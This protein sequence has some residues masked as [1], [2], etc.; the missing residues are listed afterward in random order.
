MIAKDPVAS[1]VLDREMFEFL[2]RTLGEAK[3]APHLRCTLK[4]RAGKELRKFTTGEDW[5]E[6]LDVSFSSNGFDS[7]FKMN[8]VIPSTAKYGLQKTN[9]PWSGVGEE[10]RVE[11]N[12]SYGHWLQLTHDGQGRI[13]QMMF[14]NDLRLAPCQVR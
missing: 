5:I 10:I 3:M 8:F 7:G 2:A 9:N 13:V 4:A 14:G 12:D 1:R 6:T 11:L